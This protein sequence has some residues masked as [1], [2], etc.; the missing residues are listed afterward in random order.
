MSTPTEDGIAV[1]T[2]AGENRNG[3]PYGGVAVNLEGVTYRTPGNSVNLRPWDGSA[4]LP[5]GFTPVARSKAATAKV[6][7]GKGGK[8][9][10]AKLRAAGFTDEEIAELVA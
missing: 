4:P 5:D 1:F 3:Q 9:R 2:L 8:G 10:L 7:K 6:A